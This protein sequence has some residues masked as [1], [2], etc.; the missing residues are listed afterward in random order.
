[1]VYNWKSGA[2]I[3]VSAQ[4]AGDICEQLSYSPGGLTPE[5]LLEISR[6]DTAPLHKC[7]EWDDA[8]AAEQYRIGQ[9]GQIIRSLEVE[10]SEISSDTSA[11]ATTRAFVTV[12]PKHYT[13]VDVVLKDAQ[14]RECLLEQA[15]REYESFRQKYQTLTALAPLFAA[16][17]KLFEG[18]AKSA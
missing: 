13:R 16:A 18:D 2:R 4:V 5:S 1:M 12:Q 14:S 17:D 9:A 6:P 7:F 10:I 3:P 8:K 15:R 11:A